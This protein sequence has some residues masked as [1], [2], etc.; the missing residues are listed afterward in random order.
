[1][2]LQL[3]RRQ[4]LKTS[5]VAAGRVLCRVLPLKKRSPCVSAIMR[6]LTAFQIV[7]VKR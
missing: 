6:A 7:H 4:W 5:A 1:M 3:N 2:T